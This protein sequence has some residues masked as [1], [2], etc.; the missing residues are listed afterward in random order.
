MLDLVDETTRANDWA[1]KNL[2]SLRRSF[3]LLE[4]EPAPPPIVIPAV[5]RPR[6]SISSA[7]VVSKPPDMDLIHEVDSEDETALHTSN[8]ERSSGQKP[9][10]VVSRFATASVTNPIETRVEMPTLSSTPASSSRTSIRRPIRRQSGLLS[11]SEFRPWSS[12]SPPSSPVQEVPNGVNNGDGFT[13]FDALA[14]ISTNVST[15]DHVVSTRMKD[16]GKRKVTPNV[17]AAS[18]PPPEQEQRNEEFIDRA[19]QLHD[20]TNSPP[21]TNRSI[22]ERRSRKNLVA[23]VLS[24]QPEGQDSTA[25][26]APRPRTERRR[27][28]PSIVID[29]DAEIDDR[30]RNI[31]PE[32]EGRKPSAKEEDLVIIPTA[33]LARPSRPHSPIPLAHIQ[34]PT[35]SHGDGGRERRVRKS[36]N[37]A[38]PKLNTKMRKPDG[39]GTSSGGRLS[40]SVSGAPSSSSSPP[41]LSDPVPVP[42]RKR[43][44]SADANPNPPAPSS[45]PMGDVDEPR[46]AV[47]RERERER[48]RANKR[49]F[50]EEDDYEDVHASTAVTSKNMNTVTTMNT[51]GTTISGRAGE[52]GVDLN[53]H[54]LW[55]DSSRAK[56]GI[57]ALSRRHTMARKRKTPSGVV[58]PISDDEEE[59]DVEADAYDD[60]GDDADDDDFRLPLGISGR[61]KTTSRS[62]GLGSSANGRR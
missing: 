6:S 28:V 43:R 41:P 57:K 25:A 52:N 36:I 16:K 12:S 46:N 13:E 58:A 21:P 23:T 62:R 11:P 27:K 35:A 33:T 54:G 42:T 59:P 45:S 34:L 55:H 49:A 47:E 18:N 9:L 39:Y 38:E 37:Y 56:S 19:Q 29:E 24:E 10:S 20:L 44:L 32:L 51:S 17:A 4:K 14:P 22:V 26:L 48:L 50:V 30:G 5:N 1:R 3:D 8:K 15:P 31:A 7:V 40:S 53:G 2:A 61:K 60:G